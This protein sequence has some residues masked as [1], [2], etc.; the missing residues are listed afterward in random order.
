LLTSKWPVRDVSIGANATP[1]KKMP[2]TNML[3]NVH[4]YINFKQ[5]PSGCLSD[6]FVQG[7]V[8]GI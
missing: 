4:I 1:Q 8:G 6:F 3:L 5:Q 7:G 2:C